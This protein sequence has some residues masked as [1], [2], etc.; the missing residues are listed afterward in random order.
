M[1]KNLIKILCALAFAVIL[2]AV[3]IIPGSMDPL[4]T[5]LRI[6]TGGDGGIYYVFGD[7]LANLFEKHMKTSVTVIPS[8][9][10]LDNINMLRN[11]RTDLAFVQSDIM[12]YAYNGTNQFSTEGPFKDF[13]AMASLYP[14]TRQIV[15]RSNISGISGLRGRRVSIGAE[16]SGTELNALQILNSYGI[17]YT[18][19]YADHLGF[20]SSVNA[21]NE[22]KFDAFFCTAGVPTPAI[23][24]LAANGEARLLSIGDAHARSIIS[25]YPYYSRQIIPKDIYGME[26]DTE[27]IAVK[28]VL[29]ASRRLDE[30]TV[31]KIISIMFEN[32]SEISDKVPGVSLNR[33]SAMDGLSIPLHRG[34]EEFLLGK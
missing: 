22:G 33:K 29:A 28:A 31:L 12:N 26:E 11:G 23:S 34:A 24:Q 2:F 30:K 14:E 10:S 1:R 18:D 25:Q 20:S 17:G 21:F 6:A 16:G 32:A 27:T 5:R 7:V 3:Y 19:I 13:Y 4:P 9:G 8:G 15:V